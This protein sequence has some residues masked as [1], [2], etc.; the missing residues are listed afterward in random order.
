MGVLIR[1]L[2]TQ[3]PP[4]SQMF[5]RYIG[6]SAISLIFVFLNKN[7]L[8][9]KNLSDFFLLLFIGIFGYSLS[10]IFFTF[11]VLNTNLSTVL[12]IFSTYVVITPLLTYIFLKETMNKNIWPAI[13]LSLLGTY[14][15]FK[16]DFSTINFGT[17]LALLASISASIYYTGSRKLKNYP[18]PVITA[19]STICG[20]VT[21][22]LLSLLFERNFYFTAGP[23]ISKTIV[24]ISPFIWFIVLIFAIDNFASWLFVNKG[25]QKV[26]GG[27]G[28]I[29][30]LTEPVLGTILGIVLY[31]ETLT[32]SAIIG[33]SFILG[34]ILLAMLKN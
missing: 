11:S 3:I 14:L 9:P 24:S 5:L 25:F 4:F 21:A 2:N 26:Q 31:G 7:S 19:Y 32:L 8:K 20:V 23:Q 15:L 29:I 28:S 10:T 27:T 18:S 17:I 6:S 16:P 13:V 1:T 30:L 34:G 33:I 12:F 22:S